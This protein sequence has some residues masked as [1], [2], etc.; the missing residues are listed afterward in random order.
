LAAGDPAAV[1]F[2]CELRD[3]RMSRNDLLEHRQALAVVLEAHLMVVL[4]VVV[5]RSVSAR[6]RRIALPVASDLIGQLA[7]LGDLVGGEDQRRVA[8]GV[9]HLLAQHL[10]ALAVALDGGIVADR[11]DEACDRMAEARRQLGDADMGVLHDVVEQ[12]CGDNDVRAAG[13]AQQP[14]DLQRMFDEW[15][16]IALA[17]LTGVTA[18]SE[19][20]RRS[21]ERR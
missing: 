6:R 9:T 19:R 18:R 12:S 1:E 7:Y 17:S 10:L 8:T 5:A 15:C 16:A 21:C 3:K 4:E 13:I 14:C 2:D 11:L 20:T